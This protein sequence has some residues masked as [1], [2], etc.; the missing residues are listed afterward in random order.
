[1]TDHALIALLVVVGSAVQL[2]GL[3]LLGIMARQG[4]ALIL[5][6]QRLT[7]TVGALVYQETGK[8]AAQIGGRP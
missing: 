8:L 4:R 5:E 1:M 6:S 2:V 3:I 7:K